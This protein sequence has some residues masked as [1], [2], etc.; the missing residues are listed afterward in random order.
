VSG[1]SRA[2]SGGVGAGQHF[3]VRVPLGNKSL[4]SM[5]HPK[6]VCVCVVKRTT[7]TD[8]VGWEG[9]NGFVDDEQMS[10]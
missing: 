3:Q 8:G 4:K 5:G 9:M 7:T 10:R 1:N 6:C 2:K